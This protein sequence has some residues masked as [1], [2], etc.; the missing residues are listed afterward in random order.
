MS[1]ICHTFVS[2]LAALWTP[3]EK[4]LNPWSLVCDLYCDFVTFPFGILGQVWYLIVSIPD[5]CCLSYF[6]INTNLGLKTLNIFFK[7]K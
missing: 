2:V 4:G 6:Q 5:P 7:F 3:E 1:C